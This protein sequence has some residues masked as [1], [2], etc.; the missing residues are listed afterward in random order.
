MLCQ[1]RKDILFTCASTVG[2]GTKY[3][4]SVIGQYG[5]CAGS[6]ATQF[7]GSVADNSRMKRERQIIYIKQ[8]LKFVEKNISFTVYSAAIRIFCVNTIT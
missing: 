7:N 4:Y 5:N 2:Y 3:E 1:R 8:R 6:Q